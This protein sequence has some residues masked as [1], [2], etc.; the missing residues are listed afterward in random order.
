[1]DCTVD[2]IL[3]TTPFFRPRDGCEP[4]PMTSTTPRGVTSPTMATTFEVPI[5]SPTNR[6]R[7]DFFVIV[8]FSLNSMPQRSP[9]QA[10]SHSDNVNRFG[11]AGP[12]LAPQSAETPARTARRQRPHH[13]HPTQ[14]RPHHAAL[15]SRLA[16]RPVSA[17]QYRAQW[18]QAS[19][20][21][22][23]T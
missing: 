22:A 19:L 11:S 2:S 23:E 9:K 8:F 16:A 1:M 5:S 6:L 12:H 14:A 21:N 20:L 4:M 13:Q 7:S 18:A 10:Q 17:Q 3:T 15:P